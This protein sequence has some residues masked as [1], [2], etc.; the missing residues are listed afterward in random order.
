VPAS[1]HHERDPHCDSVCWGVVYGI[2]PSQKDAVL[3][4]LNVREAGGYTTLN[5]DV[6]AS[7][8]ATSAFCNAILFS[9]TVENEFFRPPEGIRTIAHQIANSVGPSGRND[10]Y[11]LRLAEALR[12]HAI[13]D[14]HVAEL[15][16]QVLELTAAATA[17]VKAN[18]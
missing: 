17:P 8:D 2:D 13:V 6:F 10:E 11:L 3:D 14:Q 15:E 9:G 1:T 12:A 5:V 7:D 16:K 18:E 4:Y